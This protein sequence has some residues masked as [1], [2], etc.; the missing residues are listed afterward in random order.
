MV[1]RVETMTLA[2]FVRLY[3]TEGP[4]EI[5][6][7]E[8]VKLSPTLAGHGDKAKTIYDAILIFDPQKKLVLA[9]FDVPFVLLASADWVRGSRVPDIMVFRA[10]RMAQYRADNPDWEDKPFVLVPDLVVEVISANDIYTDVDTKVERYLEDGVQVVW[11]LD[12]KR[13][14]IKVQRQGTYQTLHVGNILKGDEVIPGFE[15]AVKAI[16]E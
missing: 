11:V 13:K 2:E 4:F 1:E 8:M 16:F 14:A 15:I 6:N 7:G 12:A 3:D 10:E 5:I 9:Y